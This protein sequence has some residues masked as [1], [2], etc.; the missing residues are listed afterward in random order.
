MKN[1]RSWVAVWASQNRVAS[2]ESVCNEEKKQVGRQ[3]TYKSPTTTGSSHR[4]IGK[5]GGARE[6]S[7]VRLN[8]CVR[9]KQSGSSQERKQETGKRRNGENK[10]DKEKG[11]RQDLLGTKINQHL[12]IS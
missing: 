2:G 12:I 5:S 1:R 10:G 6:Q 3:I 8:G 4:M 11:D 9:Q 7:V